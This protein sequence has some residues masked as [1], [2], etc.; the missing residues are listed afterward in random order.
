MPEVLILPSIRDLDRDWIV[1]AV[2]GSYWGGSY[3]RIQILAAMEESAM[4]GAF[5]PFEA[6]PQVPGVIIGFVR[7]VTDTAIWSSITDVYVD[8][9]HRGRGVGS[10]LM[11]AVVADDR[12]KH[13]MCILQARPAAQ[14]WYQAHWDFR[15]IDPWSGIMQRMPK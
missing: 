3:S 2:Q 12:I 8:E 15:L 7:A 4:W 5:L 11:D 14:L 1:R 6:N 9:A 13:T 10:A